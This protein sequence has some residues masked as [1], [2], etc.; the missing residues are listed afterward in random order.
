MSNLEVFKDSDDVEIKDGCRLVWACLF[1]EQSTGIVFL[2]GTVWSVRLSIIKVI[3][4]ADIVRYEAW[5]LVVPAYP[6]ALIAKVA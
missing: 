5:C 4:L 3:P 6:K 1:G 2:D